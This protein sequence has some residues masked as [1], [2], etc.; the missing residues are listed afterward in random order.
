MFAPEWDA[1]C[2]G[3]SE[4]LDNV[5]HLAHLWARDTSFAAVSRAPYTRILP[6]KARMGWTVPW[7]SSYGNDFNRD[8]LVTSGSAGRS[9]SG[10]A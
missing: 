2:A 5:G 10:P 6:F 4:F 1:G 7:Y 3:C 8:F 9:S